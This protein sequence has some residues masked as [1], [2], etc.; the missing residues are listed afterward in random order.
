M[1]KV[2]VPELVCVTA[3][4]S[5]GNV[6][7]QLGEAIVEEVLVHE[8]STVISWEL[9]ETVFPPASCTVTALLMALGGPPVVP[10]VVVIANF[11]AIPSVI[12]VEPV[13]TV[14]P[15]SGTHPSPVTV[16]V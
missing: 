2:A 15:A 11:D 14:Q 6:P 1:E 8:A 5:V 12:A 4:P 9:Q 13:V 3:P 7:W 16:K 10:P